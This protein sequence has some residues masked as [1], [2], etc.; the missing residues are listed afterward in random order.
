MLNSF[1]DE[2]LVKIY[3]HDNPDGPDH[4]FYRNLVAECGAK[5]IIDLGCGTGILTT[6]LVTPGREVIGVDPAPAMIAYARQRENGD[7]VTWITGTSNEIS[8]AA[9]ADVVLLTGNVAMHILADAWHETLQDIYRALKPGGVLAFETRNPEAQAWL[10]WQEENSTRQTPAGRVRETTRTDPPNQNGVVVMHCE[11]HFLDHEHLLNIEQELQF[12]SYEQV[13]GDL[14]QAGFKV[15]ACYRNW[16]GADFVPG[17][18]Y[19]L[20]IFVATR[21]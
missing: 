9:A 13:L 21:D 11:K 14:Q 6:T 18:R 16:H 2:L 10:D 12:R 5:K 8:E 19:P 7:N 3:D 20:M 15:Q 4:D 1:D 17:E